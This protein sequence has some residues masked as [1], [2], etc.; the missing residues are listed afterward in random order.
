VR[1]LPEAI[2]E[3]EWIEVSQDSLAAMQPGVASQR[4]S[5]TN[6]A[7]AGNDVEFGDEQHGSWTLGRSFDDVKSLETISLSY[8]P[9]RPTKSYETLHLP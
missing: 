3:F 6:D 9:F 5:V 1:G 8:T 4:Q 7:D 2:Q